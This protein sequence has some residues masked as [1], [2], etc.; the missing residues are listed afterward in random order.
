MD[1]SNPL[2]KTE[3]RC[4][5]VVVTKVGL[6]VC[7]VLLYKGQMTA[8]EISIKCWRCGKVNV[9]KAAKARERFLVHK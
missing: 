9:I 2:F 3:R 4:N 8:G 7:N 6:K 5:E 1:Q